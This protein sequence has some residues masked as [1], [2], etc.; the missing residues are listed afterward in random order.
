MRKAAVNSTLAELGPSQLSLS[1]F[2]DASYKG[3]KLVKLTYEIFFENWN[4]IFD[5]KHVR[6]VR[7]HGQA[8]AA[9]QIRNP[10]CS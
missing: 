4:A 1:Y 8:F 9:L 2:N 3:G 10:P 5:P 6:P 7:D